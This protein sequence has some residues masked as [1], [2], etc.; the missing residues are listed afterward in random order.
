MDFKEI[1]KLQMV[2]QMNSA[3]NQ[4]SMGPKMMLYQV[5][6][7]G[8]MSIIEDIVKAVPRVFESVKLVIFM[9]FKTRVKQTIDKPKT[10]NDMSV[11]LN[12]KHFQNTVSMTR[13][14]QASGE[15]K[16]NSSPSSEESNMIVDAVLSQISKL[17]NVPSLQLI[18]NG[19]MMINYKEKPIQMTKDIFFKVENINIHESG[20]INS[21]KFQVMSNTL[22]A[23]EISNYINN[24]YAMYQQEMNNSLGNKIYYFD[25]KQRDTGPPQ[26]PVGTNADAATN[27]KRMIINTAPKQLSFTM[28]PFYSNKKLSNVYGKEARLVEKR[29]RF[30]LENRDWY[31]NKGVPYQLGIMLSGVPGSGKSSI[32]KGLANMTKR[33]IVNINFSNIAT[34]TQL[35]N[36]FYSDRIQ[37]YTDN[38][39][40]NTHSY[41]I[42]IEQRLY[43]LEEIDAIGDVVKQRSSDKSCVKSSI[44]DELTL[45]EI[46]TVLDGTMEI[47]GRIIIMTTN[48]PEVLDS[49]LV[50]PGRIDVKVD[51]GYADRGLIVDM[52]EAY[53]ETKFPME[54]VDKLPN[55][56]LTPAEVGQVLFKHFNDESSTNVIIEDICRFAANTKRFAAVSEVQSI[57]SE[58]IVD[59]GQTIIPLPIIAKVQNTAPAIAKVLDT[60]PTIAKVQNTAPTIAELQNT[61]PT[62][63]EAQ[64]T[65]LPIAEVQ[66]VVSI[67]TEE[68]TITPPP[69]IAEVQNVVAAPVVDEEKTIIPEVQHIE[70]TPNNVHFGNNA[71]AQFVDE[72]QTMMSPTM[73][74]AAQEYKE[75]I[76]TALTSVTLPKDTLTPELDNFYK[77]KHIEPTYNDQNVKTGMNIPEINNSPMFSEWMSDAYDNTS[78]YATV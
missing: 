12:V 51:F 45:A 39:M 40:S 15:S 35:K 70:P 38:T 16:N 60:A 32:L 19:K 23:A 77:M 56:V 63:A 42:P 71:S 73:L 50:R 52:F 22:S 28:A 4:Q 68:H 48:H 49:A 62:I 1:I 61:A 36:L 43:V 30:F 2:T 47:P 65:A 57:A 24:L 18:D 5:L 37:V 72:L 14:Y 76:V 3:N 67:I 59:E 26:L 74:A 66:N 34:A 27:H 10:L 25:Q 11:Q 53:L 20:R 31:D 64:D 17:T 41:F 55:K 21:V 69:I 75:H 8:L 13:I 9:Y 29:V 54:M 78:S 46:L 44:Q 7:M 58:P 33:H 6:L